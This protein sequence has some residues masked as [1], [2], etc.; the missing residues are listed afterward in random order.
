MIFLLKLNDLHTTKKSYYLETCKAAIPISSTIILKWCVTKISYN[1]CRVRPK[2][3]LGNPKI[4]IVWYLDTQAIVMSIALQMHNF[5]DTPLISWS[6]F[7]LPILLDI[8]H[9]WL[10]QG[11]HADYKD[12][13]HQERPLLSNIWKPH[14]KSTT[15]SQLLQSTACDI[16]EGW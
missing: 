2:R 1:G 6:S 15:T 8:V 11:G 16:W 10:L 13:K 3:L 9:I 14:S 12:A 4:V 7:L 5:R